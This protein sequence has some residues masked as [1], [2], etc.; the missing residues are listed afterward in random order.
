MSLSGAED[1][2]VRH[3]DA[4]R[5]RAHGERSRAETRRQII[6]AATT[7]FLDQGYAATT[8]ASI[9]GAAGVVVQ[10]LYLAVGGKAEILRAVCAAAVTGGD[11][12]STVVGQPWVAAIAA[13]PDP[14]VQVRMLA[15]ESVALGVRA[16]PFWRLMREAAAEEPVLAADLAQQTKDRYRDQRA[17][18]GLL[19]GP[20]RE[21]LDQGG[22]ADIL[23]AVASPEVGE[24]LVV[25]RH[26]KL[27]R[28]ERW[29]AD[30]LTALLLPAPP[31]PRRRRG[32]EARSTGP[33]AG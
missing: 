4:R 8:M 20:L 30:I 11:P 7:L 21:G 27:E 29:W 31:P 6:E 10:T 23:F 26:W 15:R 18:V 24:L 1:R 5:R 33:P 17:F 32:K 3:Y 9:A 28:L 13:Q 22:A 12:D 14:Y 2:P 19:H 16:A 25:Q